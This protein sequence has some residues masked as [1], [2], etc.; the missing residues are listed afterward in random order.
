VS[1]FNP[2]KI[3]MGGG[4]FGPAIRFIPDIYNEAKKWAQ[5]ISMTKVSIEPS[6]IGGDAG[7]FGAGYLALRLHQMK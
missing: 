5:P 2:E 4:V 6:A 1:I 3:I 7:V